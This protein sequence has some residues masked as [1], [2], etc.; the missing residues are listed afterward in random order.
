MTS[1]V[2]S[3][4]PLISQGLPSCVQDVSQHLLTQRLTSLFIDIRLDLLKQPVSQ[5]FD[6]VPVA[7]NI[8]FDLP[9]APTLT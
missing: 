5:A 9:E 1:H 3:A 8:I 2:I 4:A 6:L 7:L